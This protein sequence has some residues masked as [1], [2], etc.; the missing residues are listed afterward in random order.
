MITSKMQSAMNEQIKHETFSAYLYFAMVAYFH[1]QNLDGM[2]QW[3]K[4]QAQEEL[5]HAQRF[6]NHINERGGRIELQPLD[7]PQAE[8]ASPIAAFKAALQHEKFITGRINDL[9]NLADEENDRA[10]GIMLQWFVTEQVEEEDSVSRI[11]SMLER[12]GDSGHGILMAD[13]ELGRRVAEA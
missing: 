5:D 3:M 4:A 6:F 12:I 10:S 1:S 7:K 9:A 11:I 8:W 2:A 13:R